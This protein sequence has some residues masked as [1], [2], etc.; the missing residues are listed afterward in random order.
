[1]KLFIRSAVFFA[2]I[3]LSMSISNN[4]LLGKNAY[5]CDR[6]FY[7]ADG[8]TL[9]QEN[10]LGLS[11][12]TESIYIHIEGCCTIVEE[13]TII[14]QSGGTQ[15]CPE[16]RSNLGQSD[17]TLTQNFLDV[18]TNLMQDFV[19][20]QLQ[21]ENYSGYQSFNTFFNGTPILRNVTWEADMINFV[22]RI[23]TNIVPQ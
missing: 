9:I 8:E 2:F 13:H 5:C 4:A 16:C 17:I 6:I 1:M 18:S 15:I 20:G 11:T 3:I 23:T 12:V 14:C 10:Q 19:Y 21:N 22:L 7:A